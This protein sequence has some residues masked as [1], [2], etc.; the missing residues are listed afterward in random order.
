MFRR[1]GWLRWYHAF[2]RCV[3]R[4][5]SRRGRGGS[6]SHRR[7]LR[8]AAGGV[9]RRLRRLLL[10][11]LRRLE[12]LLQM[13]EMKYRVADG[14]AQYWIELKDIQYIVPRLAETIAHISVINRN[15]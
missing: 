10:P 11:A 14:K 8:T 9:H 1:R 13:D 3:R 6:A 4:L 7:V 5:G 2:Y 12:D 15:D